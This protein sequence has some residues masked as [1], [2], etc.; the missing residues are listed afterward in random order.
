MGG[1][2]DVRMGGLSQEFKCGHLNILTVKDLQ[3]VNKTSNELSSIA[4]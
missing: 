3:D 2:N 4:S 1:Q